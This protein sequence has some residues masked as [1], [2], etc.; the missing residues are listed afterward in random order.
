MEVDVTHANNIQTRKVGAPQ[1][2]RTRRHRIE[3]LRKSILQYAA[4]TARRL[5]PHPS[6]LREFA[7]L[8]TR[9][10]NSDENLFTGNPFFQIAWTMALI[11]ERD[12]ESEAL[13]VAEEFFRWFRTWLRSGSA[14]VDLAR[15]LVEDA[16]H[17]TADDRMLRQALADGELTREEWLIYRG[18]RRRAIESGR[19]LITVGDEAY[20][21][22]IL[23]PAGAGA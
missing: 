1:A 16:E 21:R 10:R 6:Q 5:V 13:V 15:A 19:R 23:P 20:H 11:Y 3:R 17:D 12:P 14:S 18:L 4:E 8:W 7:W 22:G 2:K 9:S